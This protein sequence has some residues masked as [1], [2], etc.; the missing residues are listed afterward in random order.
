MNS[1]MLLA[2]RVSHDLQL[3]EGATF[4]SSFESELGDPRSNKGLK[5]VTHIIMGDF[6]LF[7][8]RSLECMEQLRHTDSRPSLVRPTQINAGLY[9][10]SIA[11][12]QSSYSVRSLGI[13]H[14]LTVADSIPPKF[15]E[16]KARQR[17]Q[18]KIIEVT[19]ED[20]SHLLPHLDECVDFIHRAI[21]DGGNILVHCLAGVSRSATV[22]AAYLM[23]VDGLGLE[24][25]LKHIRRKR[26][27]VNPNPG[28]I[29]QLRQYAEGIK[30]TDDFKRMPLI[31][32]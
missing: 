21:A 25:A 32:A 28:F 8:S 2:S 1:P 18:Y 20:T 19:D 3:S 14:I 23:K 11:A 15:P 22:V 26:P 24:E 7:G 30:P 4:I 17:I 27:L 9:L 31:D 29:S 12:A 16:V 13:T 5:D 6:S 10:G